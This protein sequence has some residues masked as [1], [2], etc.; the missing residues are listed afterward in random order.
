MKFLYIFNLSPSQFWGCVVIC[1][2]LFFL[3]KAFS[4]DGNALKGDTF[5]NPLWFTT[6]KAEYLGVCQITSD[7]ILV[8]ELVA[9]TGKVLYDTKQGDYL[10]FK[11][12]FPPECRLIRVAYKIGDEFWIARP[13]HLKRFAPGDILHLSHG[14]ILVVDQTNEIVW[15]K[16]VSKI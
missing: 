13:Q 2:I 6:L 8:L 3:K 1:S 10:R 7:K 5:Q 4:A 14:A 16:K 11:E 9:G 12:P 15:D